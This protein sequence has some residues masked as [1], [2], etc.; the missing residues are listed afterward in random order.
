MPPYR[1]F[2]IVLAAG[3]R[4]AAT[5]LA[6]CSVSKSG[7]SFSSVPSGQSG[8]PSQR[9]RRGIHARPRPQY[10]ELLLQKEQARSSD[11]SQGGCSKRQMK[12]NA[13]RK[14]SASTSS[15]NVMTSSYTSSNEL[16][17]N[18]FGYVHIANR[19]IEYDLTRQALRFHFA[20]MLPL[21]RNV[22]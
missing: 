11:R 14:H 21:N 5:S 12:S 18:K 8:L 3:D 10:N 20:Q 1:L 16:W 4:A 6:C 9:A 17:P 22:V 7:L 19:E 15:R 13:S 2:L